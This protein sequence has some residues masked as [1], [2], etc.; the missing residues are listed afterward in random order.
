MAKCNFDI[1]F[2][3][4]KEKLVERAR[5]GITSK[6]GTFEG[7]TEAWMFSM[8]TPAGKVVASYTVNGNLIGFEI[9]DKPFVVSCNRIEDE[10]R[11]RIL[12]STQNLSA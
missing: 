8:P 4:P 7:N 12:S 2:D 9:I 3:E 6:G 11:K 5:N 1:E 10:L